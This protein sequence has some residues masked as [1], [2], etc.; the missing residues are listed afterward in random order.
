MAYGLIWVVSW[1]VA[2]HIGIVGILEGT[3]L[4][5]DQDLGNEQHNDGDIDQDRSDMSDSWEVIE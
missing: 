3:V 2:L 1:T 5:I 4:D